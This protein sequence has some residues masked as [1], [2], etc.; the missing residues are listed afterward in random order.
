ME[1]ARQDVAVELISEIVL[2]VRSPAFVVVGALAAPLAE[3]A[4]PITGTDEFT[5]GAEW[6]GIE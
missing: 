4:E 1:L 6:V 3:L 5:Y 2:V